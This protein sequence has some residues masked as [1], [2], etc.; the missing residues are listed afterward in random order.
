[1]VVNSDTGITQLTTAQLRAIYTGQVTNWSQVGGSN[2]QIIILTQPAGS[3]MRTIFETFVLHGVTQ[4][5]SGTSTGP[6]IKNVTGSITYLPL[7]DVA[8][9]GSGAQSI[10]INGVVPSASSVA[11]GSYPFWA[12]EHLYTNHVAQGAALSFI[13]FCLTSAGETDLANSGAVP[14]TIMLASALRSHMPA[15]TV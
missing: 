4:T 3:T 6:S 14:Y 9:N 12:I 15:P 5:V 8:G 11:S 1:V 2:E 7:A 13:G 10:A